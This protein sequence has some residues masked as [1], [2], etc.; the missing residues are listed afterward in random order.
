M[1]DVEQINQHL[2]GLEA[3]LRN[4]FT[5]IERRIT[6]IEQIKNDGSEERSQ[7]LEDLMLLL[8][9]ENE[10]TREMLGDRGF[11]F[12]TSDSS[13]APGVNQDVEEK[14]IALQLFK[15]L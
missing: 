15:Y 5:Q 2:S 14:I 4:T 1:E 3:K 6:N 13:E 11:S 7:E 9:V 8:Q 12:T 10:K